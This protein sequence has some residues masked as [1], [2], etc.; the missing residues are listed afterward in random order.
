MSGLA[1]EVAEKYGLKK[2]YPIYGSCPKFGMID[3]RTVNVEGADSLFAQ[4]FEGLELKK[5]KPVKEEKA[6]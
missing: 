1:K 6:S 2:D 5:T 4:G 3:L